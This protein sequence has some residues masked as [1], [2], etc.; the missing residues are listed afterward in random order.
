MCFDA[1]Y[2]FLC[3]ISAACLNLV[4]T[5]S[6]FIRILEL[7]D[8]PAWVASS[9]LASALPECIKAKD[10]LVVDPPVSQVYQFVQRLVMKSTN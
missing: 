10:A 2:W 5:K 9:V 8:F 6:F 1:G 7:R 4:V 3:D